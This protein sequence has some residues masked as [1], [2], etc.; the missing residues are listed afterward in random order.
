MDTTRE[1]RGSVQIEDDTFQ[2]SLARLSQQI[3]ARR[4]A[5][6]MPAPLPPARRQWPAWPF[7]LLV[8]VAVAGAA[9][10]GYHY[11]DLIDD[12]PPATR[13]AVAEAPAARPVLAAIA[14]APA[15]VAPPAAAK[16]PPARAVLPTVPSAEPP[17]PVN[18]TAAAPSTAPEP[19]I[20]LT[21]AEVLE[22]QKRLASMGLN[23]GPLDGIAGPLTTAGVQRYEERRGNP[24]TGK[25]DRRLLKLL[26]Q[27][28]VPAALQAQAY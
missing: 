3:A 12:D 2:Q 6:L 20:A 23:P 18:F 11:A 14:T 16:E 19:E 1:W 22:V 5:I 4:S 8:A 24:A 26:Q 21:W 7:L 15:P 27:D 28:T 13:P 9:A 17:P 10:A 25:V